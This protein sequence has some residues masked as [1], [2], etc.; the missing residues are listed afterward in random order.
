M[1]RRQGRPAPRRAADRAGRA[2]R[3]GGPARGARASS[4]STA[5]AGPSTSTIRRGTGSGSA[6]TRTTSPDPGAAVILD[7]R[8]YGTDNYVYLLAEGDDAALVD[9]GDPVVAL[10][11]AAA[12]GL[13]PRWILHTHGHAD[14]TGGSAALRDAARRAR[15]RAR[16]GRGPLR[17]G[18]GPRR[19][20]RGRARR[21][22]RP[23]PPAP[24]HTPGR[25][26]LRGG[27]AAPHRRHAV[28]G[29]R[30]E[31]PER[32]R[33]GGARA[34]VPDGLPGA[35][36]RARGPPRPRLRRGEPP[37]RAAG[38]SRATRRP[39]RRLEAVR[40]ARAAGAEPAP[41]TLAEE[42][43]VNPFLRAGRARGPRRRRGAEGRP[44][45]AP[46]RRRYSWPCGRFARSRG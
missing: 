3:L 16:R 12:H 36:R 15:P 1:A 46:P 13:R 30:R 6:T 32:R 35:R 34:D 20:R 37:V 44:R 40:A 22:P 45:R 14:H 5:P 33:S 10:G 27:R 28:L 38:S 18:R 25:G 26:A 19:A 29:R 8:R 43:A 4:S 41:T 23:R 21:A 31:L 2:A 24:G 7:R 42:R 39:R 11:M 17:A 9:P